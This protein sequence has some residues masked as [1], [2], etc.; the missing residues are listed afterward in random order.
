MNLQE[1]GTGVGIVAFNNTAWVKKGVWEL[2]TERAVFRELD[3]IALQGSGGKL[4]T[5]HKSGLV[6]ANIHTWMVSVTHTVF[7]GGYRISE[8]GGGSG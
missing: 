7:K 6:M 4:G 5:T 1:G 2:D 8:G 3:K